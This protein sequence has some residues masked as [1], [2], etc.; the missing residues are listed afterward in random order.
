MTDLSTNI[1]WTAQHPTLFVHDEG[2][3]GQTFTEDQLP[4]PDVQRASGI[5]PV[6]YRSA[7][8]LIVTPAEGPMPTFVGTETGVAPHEAIRVNGNVESFISV[9]AESV[10]ASVEP[11]VDL[12]EVPVEEVVTQSVPAE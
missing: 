1:G 4:H 3:P 2:E 11:S 5:D 9:P 6:L 8:G 10:A 12:T 7:H